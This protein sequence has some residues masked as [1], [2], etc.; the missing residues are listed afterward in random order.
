[1]AL[2]E[3][4]LNELKGYFDNSKRPMIVFDDDPDGFTSF[5]MV[6]RYIGEGRG[7]PDKSNM[8][9]KEEF[10][11][12]INN[13][14]PDLVVL[15]D[16]PKVSQ[17]FIN[18]IKAPVVWVD[19][20]PS[21][22]DYK[23]V[24][25]FNPRL[26]DPADRS[27]TSYW[28]YKT[29]KTDL[30]IAMVGMI[31]DWFVP[32]KELWDEL[33]KEYPELLPEKIVSPEIAHHD[34]IIGKLIRI[35]AFNL[36]GRINDVITSM[37]V[38]TRVKSPYEILNQ[39]TSAGKLIYKRYEKMN[40]K[41]RLIMKNI[42]VKSKDKLIVVKYQTSDFSFS[43]IL[44]NELIYKYPEKVLVVA[45][46]YGGEYKCSVRSTDAIL[47]PII[48]ESLEGLDGGGGGHEHAVG[49]HVAVND[50][51]EFIKRFRKILDNTS[52]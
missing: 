8:T 35:F 20:H 13:Y 31:G 24:A 21:S 28:I 30:W 11:E 48:K 51:D 46:E 19:H 15:L 45:W 14:Y 1:M 39:E 27:P 49:V 4:Q 38:F 10:A 43:A 34:T 50:F 7:I 40:E 18:A 3:E 52:S 33:R 2:S 5:L 26:S 23:G 12:K 17:E 36:K 22:D 41:Y 16:L 9:M 25:R 37:K 29:L 47:P 32:E 6:Y 42:K 44:S